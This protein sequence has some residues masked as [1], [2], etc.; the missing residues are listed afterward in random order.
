ME[1]SSKEVFGYFPLFSFFGF[2]V[3]VHGISGAK[4]TWGEGEL[5]VHNQISSL[6]PCFSYK[7][8]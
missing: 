7:R 2:N 4:V 6:L 3:W 1:A 5:K 8:N